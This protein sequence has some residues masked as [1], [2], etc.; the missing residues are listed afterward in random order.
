MAAS[1]PQTAAELA[2]NPGVG[3]RKREA[4]GQAFLKV[5]AG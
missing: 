3:A 2:R 1:R 5:L 4:D